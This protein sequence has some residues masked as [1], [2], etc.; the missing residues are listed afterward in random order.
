MDIHD[1]GQLHWTTIAASDF[2][3]VYLHTLSGT[4][5]IAHLVSLNS[6][7]SSNTQRRQR[8]KDTDIRQV[9]ERI[10]WRTDTDIRQAIEKIY[11]RTYTD[12]RQAI[13]RL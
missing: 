5:Y 12:I 1:D 10:Q 9:I 4:S 3:G 7:Y 11:W 8:R 2:S 13:E 6:F